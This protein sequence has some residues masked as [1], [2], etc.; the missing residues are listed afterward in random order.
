[1]FTNALW[2]FRP[3]FDANADILIVSDGEKIPVEESD[4]RQSSTLRH[5]LNRKV[6]VTRIG[7]AVDHYRRKLRAVQNDLDVRLQLA[8]RGRIDFA[9]LGNQSIEENS[10]D[11]RE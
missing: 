3:F 4:E 9:R 1:M 11:F 7:F 6:P 2:V 10:L 5:S 8:V